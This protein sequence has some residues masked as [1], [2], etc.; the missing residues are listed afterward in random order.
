MISI[1][2]SFIII[3]M[4]VVVRRTHLFEDGLSKTKQYKQH[5]KQQLIQHI[6]TEITNKLET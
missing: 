1:S 6:Y 3:V 5:T 2:S 4:K